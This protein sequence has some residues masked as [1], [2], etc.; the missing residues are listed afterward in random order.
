MKKTKA[1]EAVIYF[2]DTPLSCSQSVFSTYS[3]ELGLEAATAMKI[4][5]SFGGGIAG[6]AQ[7]CGAVTGAL[8]II[9]LK[10]GY[11]LGS[12]EN[13]KTKTR[14]LSREFLT[15]FK[16]KHGSIVCNGL[17]PVDIDTEEGKK[18]AVDNNYFKNKCPNF[19]R[20]AAEI[21]EQIINTN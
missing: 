12:N 19:V 18:S 10:Y 20:S 9:G 2:L 14:S 6:T 13:A 11:S 4:A 21:L 8:M 5:D 15:R 17:L 1:D 16:K 3:G 7:T